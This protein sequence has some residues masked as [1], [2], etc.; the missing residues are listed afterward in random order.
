VAP[1]FPSWPPAKHDRIPLLTSIADCLIDRVTDTLI[2]EW[3]LHCLLPRAIEIDPSDPDTRQRA[4]RHLASSVGR[5]RVPTRAFSRLAEGAPLRRQ[6]DAIWS[7][8]AW[9]EDPQSNGSAESRDSPIGEAQKASRWA[10]V[11]T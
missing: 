5:K 1:S 2:R 6:R 4:Y 7:A 8:L 3:T 11:R 10:E 9:A